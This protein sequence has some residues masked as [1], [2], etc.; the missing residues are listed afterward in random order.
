MDR[1][2]K[3]K[4][5]GIAATVLI[6]ALLIGVVFASAVSGDG[7][8]EPDLAIDDLQDL[9]RRY[10]V[11]ENDVLFATNEL[12]NYLNG[13]ILDSDT[14]V[15]ATKTGE[16]PEGLKEGE[17]YD[18]VISTKEMRAIIEDAKERHIKKYGVDPA[19]PKL[20]DVDGILLPNEEVEK[21]VKS[22]KIKDLG[23]AEPLTGIRGGPHEGPHAING[24]LDICIFVAKDSRHKPIQ[25]INDTTDDALF[26]FVQEF[27]VGNDIRW[28]WNYWDASDV[29]PA[30]STSEAL[31]DLSADCSWVVTQENDIVIGWMHDMDHNGRAYGDGSYA[32]CSDT[33]SGYD[34]PHDSIV[35]HEVSHLFD[36][37]EGGWWCYEHPECVMN[38]CWA[39]LHG[40][41]IW[42]TSC[43]ATVNE[44]I[45]GD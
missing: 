39:A 15:V 30:D 33:A 25:D 8:K 12:P 6:T 45:W 21:L 18:I 36:A 28:K 19:N 37:P 4:G 3:P 34:W 14:R 40:T 7:S 23:H 32:V 31:G 35:Q 16:P 26:R 29:S 43:R 10:N 38:Y 24:K 2:T 11:T 44:N 17:D 5:I 22:G 13:T 27:G 20:D 1:T 42:C 9:Y 41:D